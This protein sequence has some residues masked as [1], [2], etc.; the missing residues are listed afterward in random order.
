MTLSKECLKQ[1]EVLRDEDIDYSDIPETDEA[2]WEKAELRMPKPKKGIY[3]H[4]DQ[5]LPD[6]LKG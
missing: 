6:W 1:I 3:L 4:L 5:D 2:F